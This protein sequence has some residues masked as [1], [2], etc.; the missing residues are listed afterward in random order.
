MLPDVCVLIPTYNRG[1]LL[2]E[3]LGYLSEN[4]KY[5]GNVKILIGD[6][7]DSDEL[8]FNQ[9]NRYH[10][11]KYQVAY[12]RHSPRKGLGANLNWLHATTDC[13]YLLVGDD[14][15]FFKKTVDIT[16]YVKKLMED[17]TAGMVRLFGVAG[18]NLTATLE[19]SFWRV[20]WFSPEL[21]IYS[22]RLSLRKRSWLEMYGPYPEGLKLG[23]TE[24]SYAH[25]CIDKAR[26][27]IASGLPTLDVL[28][29][30]ESPESCLS[31]SGHSWQLEGF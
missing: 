23:Q 20:S 28:V 9:E 5:E 17:D 31:E 27:N 3:N 19:G 4:L 6:D 22:N 11:C 8:A 16:P 7:S 15:H 30:L 29:A 26:L 18:H 1:K 2:D 13:E 10:F 14:D 24:E 25:T 12:Q 21:Y